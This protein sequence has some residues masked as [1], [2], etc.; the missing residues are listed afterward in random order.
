ML[1]RI[2]DEFGNLC[3]VFDY[4]ERAGDTRS[5]LT[6]INA[7]DWVFLDS[8]TGTN[9]QVGEIALAADDGVDDLLRVDVTALSFVCGIRAEGYGRFVQPGP[10]FI[11]RNKSLT[12]WPAASRG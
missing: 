10:R 5:L 8:R 11:S 3:P 4:L 1:K 2:D 9:E 7:M 12:H 6:L